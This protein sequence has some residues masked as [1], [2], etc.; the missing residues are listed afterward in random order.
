MIGQINKNLGETLLATFLRIGYAEMTLEDKNL[1]VAYLAQEDGVPITKITEKY[2]FE[3]LKQHKIQTLSARCEEAILNGFF[4]T[5]GN[6]YRTNR[7]DQINMIG[8]KDLLDSR[9]NIETVMWKTENH[10]YLPHTKEDWLKY[11]YYFALDFKSNQLFRYNHLK[12][13][14]TT[15]PDENTVIAIEWE[16]PT[17]YDTSVENVGDKTEGQ[18]EA[19]TE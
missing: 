14:V 12:T 8:Q 3:R 16:T 19:P 4:S 17:P 11:V 18:E 7:D 15:A 6:F 9:Q 5:N 10:G 1:F 13:L 2:L